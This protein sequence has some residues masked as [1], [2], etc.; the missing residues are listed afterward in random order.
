MLRQTL[1]SLE[2]TT[3]G[4]GFDDITGAINGQ[5]AASGCSWAAPPS[6]ASTRL[7]R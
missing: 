1:S 5:I 3:K 6:P 4:E 2:L 7:V